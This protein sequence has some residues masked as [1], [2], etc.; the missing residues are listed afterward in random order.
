MTSA[1]LYPLHDDGRLPR[2]VGVS[3]GA[4]LTAKLVRRYKRFLADVETPDGSILTVHCPNPGSMLGCST[5]GAAVR[6]SSSDD[7]RRKLQ[8]TL[9]MI[10]C[11]RS[12]VGVHPARANQLVERA[13]QVNA[14]STLTGY[15]EVKREVAVGGGS[16]LDFCLRGRR[17][18]GR[19]A[20]LEVKSASLAQGRRGRFPDSVTERGR[21]HVETLARVHRA[22]A[23]AGLLF[24]VQRADCDSLEPADDIDPGYGRALREA[25]QAGV[26]VWAVGARVTAREIRME[27]WLPVVL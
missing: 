16:R 23:R 5:P 19:P 8:H 3:V 20:Y 18:D 10:R 6:C 12:W 11:G 7:P 9:E 25:V 14:L 13:L 24:V 1:S 15:A 22:G 27:R 21:R 26:E 4:H 2:T 17:R